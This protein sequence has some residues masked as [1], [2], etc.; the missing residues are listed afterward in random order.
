[1]DDLDGDGLGD[2]CDADDDGDGVTDA[3]DAFPGDAAASVD[4][5]GDGQPDDYNPGATPEQRESSLLIV[6]VDDD[7]DGVNDVDDNCPL[8]INQDQSDRDHDRLGD[9][10]D[11]IENNPICF[12]MF[13]TRGGLRIIC[14]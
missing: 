12:P 3:V 9:A 2:A 8:V 5:D 7:G 10:C 6:D 13:D 1:Q 11:R 14:I 4:T